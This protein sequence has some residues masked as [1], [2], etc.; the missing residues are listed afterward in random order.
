MVTLADSMPTKSDAFL[1]GID[2]FYLQFNDV[3][4]YIEDEEQE[5]FYFEIFKN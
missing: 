4:F 5:N 2:I 1:K 3:D